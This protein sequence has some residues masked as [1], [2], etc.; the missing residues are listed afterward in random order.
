M[1]INIASVPLEGGV[2]ALIVGL[3]RCVVRETGWRIVNAAV[4]GKCVGIMMCINVMAVAMK[5][6]KSAV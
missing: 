5:K 1:A 3:A 4:V 6:K 2:N